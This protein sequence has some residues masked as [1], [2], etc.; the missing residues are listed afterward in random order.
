VLRSRD[1][2]RTWGDASLLADGYVEPSLCV[3]P[4]G[5]LIGLVAQFM[6]GPM[7]LWS[8]MILPIYLNRSVLCF[9]SDHL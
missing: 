6:P 9:F 2:G 5:R 4:S 8:N 1:G 3:L 7:P